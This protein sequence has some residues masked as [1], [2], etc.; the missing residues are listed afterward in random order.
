[1]GGRVIGNSKSYPLYL[2]AF[3][4]NMLQPIHKSFQENVASIWND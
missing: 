1:M 3:D 2:D 4:I